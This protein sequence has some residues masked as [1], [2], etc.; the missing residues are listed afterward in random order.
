MVVNA[1]LAAGASRLSSARLKPGIEVYHVA[2][3]TVNPLGTADVFRFSLEHFRTFPYKDSKGMPTHIEKLKLFNSIEDF[4][5][6]IEQ[7]GE[8]SNGSTSQRFKKKLAEQSKHMAKMYQPYTFYKGSILK[9]FV[10]QKEEIYQR[11]RD[12]AAEECSIE[13]H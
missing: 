2:S 11:V 6:Y 7:V 4:N 1:M 10:T 8:A 13:D 3:S 9:E 5:S 12:D